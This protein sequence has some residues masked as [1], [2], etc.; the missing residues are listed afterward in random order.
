MVKLSAST[1]KINYSQYKHKHVH[2]STCK[3]K[4][5]K[6]T[7]AIQTLS[8]KVR[9]MY[10]LIKIHAL[11]RTTNTVVSS[12]MLFLLNYAEYS[13]SYINFCL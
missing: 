2:V 4:T 6:R 3:I 8:G 10:G 12:G 1:Y 9:K 5:E 13:F 7:F 11:N